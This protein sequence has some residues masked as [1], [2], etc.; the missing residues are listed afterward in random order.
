MKSYIPIAIMVCLFGCTTENVNP[1]EANTVHLAGYLNTSGGIAVV[2]YWKDGAYTSLTNDSTY[3]LVSSLYVDESSVLIGGLKKIAGSPSQSMIWQDGVE[4][5][6]EEA[7]GSPFI[8]SRNNSLFGVWRSA[9]GW[10]YNK[11]STSQRIIDTAYNFEPTAM[12]LNG[13]DIYISGYSSDPS[14]P[15]D[16]ASAQHAQYWRN[17]KLMFREIEAS[18]AVSIFIHQ[19]NVYLAGYLYEPGATKTN[20]CY[21]KNGKRVNLKDGSANAVARSIFVTDSHVYVS[22]MINDEA[23]YWQDGEPILLTSGGPFSMANSIFVHGTDVHVA[24]YEQG[25]PAYWKNNIKQ[26]ISNHDKRGQVLFVVV[27]SN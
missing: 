12:T 21:W 19:G 1:K 15:P 20:A 9:T 23:V 13:D 6:I 22:G 14:S 8:A 17:E 4:T 24:G 11:Y 5:V 27:G 26:N 2:S 10:V 3:T 16:Y 25:Y 18:N 7:F